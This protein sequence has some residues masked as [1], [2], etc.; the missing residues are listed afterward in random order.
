VQ[1]A[2]PALA[3]YTV[4]SRGPLPVTVGV[5][6]VILVLLDRTTLRSRAGPRRTESTVNGKPVPLIVSV[7][8]PYT[9]PLT[10]EMLV[11]AG[12]ALYV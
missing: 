2:F 9:E 8:P 4:T 6:P 11:T 12:R 5:T 3:V 7:I 1:L 10:G